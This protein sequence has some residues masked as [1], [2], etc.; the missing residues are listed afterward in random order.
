[1]NGEEAPRR[2]DPPALHLPDG[3]GGL[4]WFFALLEK[5]AP[6]FFY[7]CIDPELAICGSRGKDRR[8]R[9]Y[10]T[11]LLGCAALVREK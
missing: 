11:K 6:P 10:H 1:M 7:Q 2:R 9:S 5:P 8:T 4:S 3:A